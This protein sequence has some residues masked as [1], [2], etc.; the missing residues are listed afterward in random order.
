MKSSCRSSR[1]TVSDS[2]NE[3]RT[4]DPLSLYLRD[5]RLVGP[6]LTAE[7]ELEFGRQIQ[8]A[9]ARIL[10][11]LFQN[12]LVQRQTV[13]L[14][15]EIGVLPSQ[16]QSF[17]MLPE[18]TSV[19]AVSEL[20]DH[21]TAHGKRPGTDLRSARKSLI[22][23]LETSLVLAKEDL[24]AVIEPFVRTTRL[25][26]LEA[27]TLLCAS[28][29]SAQI[30][31]RL[32]QGS[33]SPTMVEEYRLSVR[34][35]ITR[36]EI[37]PEQLLNSIDQIS[38][39]RRNKQALIGDLARQNLR[40]VVSIANRFHKQQSDILDL[41]AAGNTGLIEAA[42]KFDPL[43]G[44]RF[45]THA[46]WWI[47]RAIR[48]FLI[49]NADTI[50]VPRYMH[51]QRR[52]HA[53][54]LARLADKERPTMPSLAQTRDAM[55]SQSSGNSKRQ[56]SLKTVATCAGLPTS[57]AFSQRGKS[58]DDSAEIQYADPRTT[59]PDAR[60]EFGSEMTLVAGIVSTLNPLSRRIVLARL[61]QSGDD[62]RTLEEIGTEFAISKERVRQIQ[63]ALLTLFSAL[64][65]LSKHR[66]D[67]R[68]EAMEAVREDLVNTRVD[69]PL[70]PLAPLIGEDG[71]IIQNAFA[72]ET[73][74]SF[75]VP[76]GPCLASPEAAAPLAHLVLIKCQAHAHER[77]RRSRL[78]TLSSGL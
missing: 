57:V 58:N 19:S 67:D 40:L 49:D 10:D 2:C 1:D 78:Q 28:L 8:H 44:A 23:Q 11:V 26:P 15:K 74:D 66:I 51:E 72:S 22:E 18:D 63:K 50:R 46:T 6:L 21:I 47:R 54:A 68:I 77:G 12:P 42:E 60:S 52:Q 76:P 35:W 33:A 27:V 24:L 17:V 5:V 48:E 25:T 36:F 70:A 4:G 56:I 61:A 41:I 53:K 59:N 3:D 62:Q 43:R 34:E 7:Q 69:D 30:A 39:Y 73:F 32:F 38:E 64:T 9:Q 65:E 75:K 45:S 16:D 13:R 20:I 71:R 29:P 14:A 31:G 55:E 37:Q